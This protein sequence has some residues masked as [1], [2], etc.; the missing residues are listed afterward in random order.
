MQNNYT[1]LE[2][3]KKNKE[4]RASR[5]KLKRYETELLRD[6]HFRSALISEGQ[7][8]ELGSLRWALIVLEN[9]LKTM[10]KEMEKNQYQNG[11]GSH[12]QNLYQ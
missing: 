9:E 7:I 12:S 6:L 10:K 3:H 4:V 1:G 2:L 5:K 11:V 8:N